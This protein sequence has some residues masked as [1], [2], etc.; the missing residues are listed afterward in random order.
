MSNP[1]DLSSFDA[2][3]P[4][5][6]GKLFGLPFAP[7]NASVVIVPVPWEATVTYG[8][9]T[10]DGP[11]AMLKAS[12]QVDFFMRDIPNAWQLGVAMQG[13]PTDIKVESLRVRELARYVRDRP[14][15]DPSV[16]ASKIN[17]ACESLNVFVKRTCEELLDAGKVVGVLGGDHSTPLGLMRALS[18]RHDRFGILQIDAHADL[19]K[20][21]EGFIYSHGSIMFNALKMPAV[22][23]LTQVGIRD[24]C[25][26][27]F[28]LIVQNKSRIKTFFDEEIHAVSNSREL[29]EQIVR[30]LPEKVYISF[31]IDGLD[32]KLCPHTGTPVP[33]GLDFYFATSL[34]RAVVKSRRK[35]IGFDLCEVAPGPADDWD[36]NVGSRILWHL[37]CWAAVSNR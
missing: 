19:R 5:L 22:H 3:G 14:E 37:A 4:G 26:E 25:E 17:E 9:G 21:Y 23:K 12:R 30:E 7:E 35:I 2:N 31:D 11:S 15:A 36:A 24:L 18:Q 8:T 16:I 6:E 1:I 20:A 13:L 33:G 29:C 28:R 27:E 32:P 34:I 10:A